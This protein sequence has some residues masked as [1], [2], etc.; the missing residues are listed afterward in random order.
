MGRLPQKPRRTRVKS[1]T[2]LP[3]CHSDG[4]TN[5]KI[6]IVRGAL[7]GQ[8]VNLAEVAAKVTEVLADLILMA[9]PDE[10]STL[11][12][13]VLANLGSF[14][15]EKKEDADSTSPRRSSH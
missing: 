12:A 7:Q 1:T 13:D 8:E 15:L 14:V 2:K 11:M 3:A 5:N 6:V 9:P 10:Q 4:R